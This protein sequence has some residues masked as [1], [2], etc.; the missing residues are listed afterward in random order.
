MTL[1]SRPLLDPR[2][3]MTSSSLRMGTA[4][5][6]GGTG[7]KISVRRV[8][9]VVMGDRKMFGGVGILGRTYIV[10]FTQLF[11]Q[12]GGHDDSAD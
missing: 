12:G 4:R 6:W 5:T 11:V 2:V 8:S 1:P 3:M 9:K 10:L 7:S